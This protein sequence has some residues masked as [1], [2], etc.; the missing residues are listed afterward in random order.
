MKKLSFL[1]ALILSMSLA[2]SSCSSKKASFSI[3]KPQATTLKPIQYTLD[4]SKKDTSTKANIYYVENNTQQLLKDVENMFKGLKLEKDGDNQY[5]GVSEDGFDVSYSIS[6][7]TW[8][9]I[10]TNVNKES[11][12]EI[13]LSDSECIEIAKNFLDNHN[14]RPE[15]FDLASV[16][17]TST[18]GFNS[19]EK[20]IKKNVYFYPTLNDKMI[21]GNSRIIVDI[22]SNGDITEIWG[23]NR[24][25]K[26]GEEK[27]AKIISADKAIDMVLNHHPDISPN[28]SGSE[29]Y[30]TIERAE[31]LYYSDI[32][33]DTI[34]PIW[35]IAGV[36]RNINDTTSEYEAILPAVYN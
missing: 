11:T 33:M 22:N 15:N 12:E 14:I 21:Y 17:T 30:V 23:N 16:G 32:E 36:A 3:P 28:I 7:N 1:L 25:I 9:A 34:Q 31:I 27:E 6:D 26:K 35:S 5:F 13:T 8:K 18:G 10:Y 29:E 24:T 2:F 19:P 4:V 20:V